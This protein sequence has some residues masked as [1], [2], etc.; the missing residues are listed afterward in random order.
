VQEH[1]TDFLPKIGKMH[2][3]TSY[4]ILGLPEPPKVPFRGKR[5]K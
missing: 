1:G 4:R 5:P 3:R 2:F